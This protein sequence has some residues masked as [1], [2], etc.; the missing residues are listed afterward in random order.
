MPKENSMK[1]KREATIWENM[2]ANHTSDKVFIS[3]IRNELTQLHS[4]RQ[5]T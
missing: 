1:I 3:R 4:G 2:F 5:T